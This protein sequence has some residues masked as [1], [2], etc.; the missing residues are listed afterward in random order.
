MKKEKKRMEA[1]F[2][3]IFL[4]IRKDTKPLVAFWQKNRAFGVPTGIFCS[5]VLDQSALQKPVFGAFCDQRFGTLFRFKK[6][7]VLS[8]KRE[9]Y[10][11]R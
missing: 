7:A 2:P 10:K 9:C 6:K 3:R 11:K 1:V 8:V 5:Q 4:E